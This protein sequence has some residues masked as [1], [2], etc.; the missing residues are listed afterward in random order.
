MVNFQA[1]FMFVI[2][3]NTS[4]IEHSGTQDDSPLC[5][6]SGP[7]QHQQQAASY[8]GDTETNTHAPAPCDMDSCVDYIRCNPSKQ[9]LLYF[10]TE[11]DSQSSFLA[12]NA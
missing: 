2:V 11:T 5:R 8:R 9:F 6:D 12:G 4:R 10:Y 3:W 7:K 1:V